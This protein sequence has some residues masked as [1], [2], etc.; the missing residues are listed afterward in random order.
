MI[1]GVTNS[2]DLKLYISICINGVSFIVIN[3]LFSLVFRLFTM[4]TTE[5]KSD[6]ESESASKCEPDLP[7]YYSSDPQIWFHHVELICFSHRISDEESLY[8]CISKHIPAEAKDKLENSTRSVTTE[9]QYTNMKQSILYEIENPKTIRLRRRFM[10]FQMESRLP[11]T[12]LRIMRG[13]CKTDKLTLRQIWLEKLPT[14]VRIQLARRNNEVSNFEE[15]VKLA[16]K[17]FRGLLSERDYFFYT[18]E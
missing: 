14:R 12:C 5:S 4:S 11:S 3:S 2:R 15:E 7:P 9:L 8:Q 13:S 16:D 6:I 10:N 18:K 17:I 1:N